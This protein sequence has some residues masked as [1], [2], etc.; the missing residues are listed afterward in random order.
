MK[1][2]DAWGFSKLDTYWTCPQKFE[3]QFIKKLKYMNQ[4]GAAMDRGSK[5]HADIESW[6][7][8][9]AQE[10][11]VEA[12]LHFLTRFTDLKACDF[13]AESA[14]GFNKDWSK[15]SDW[16][17][18]ECWLRVKLDAHYTAGAYG[19]VIDFKTGKYRVPSVEQVELYALSAF[20]VYPELEEID[21]EFWFIDTGEVYKKTFTN[22]EVP[23][24]KKKY[25][26]YV[27]PLYADDTWSPRPS[28]ECRWCAHSKT[29][30][31]S[32]VY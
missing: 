10:L 6:L 17:G 20:C 14:W 25:E 5:I 4:G 29:K 13:K 22:S 15:R 8:G 3:A 18:K 27:K 24:L 9:W 32:C 21:A 30:G 26:D 7:N 19:V 12:Q 11:P 2:D 1:F 23:A 28:N 16:F 31:G